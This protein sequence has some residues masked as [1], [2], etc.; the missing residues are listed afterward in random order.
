MRL[1]LLSIAA[2]SITMTACA[3]TGGVPEPFPTPGPRPTRTCHPQTGR[4]LRHQSSRRRLLHCRNGSR[5]TRCTV[6]ERWFGPSRVRLQRTHRV[7]LQPAWD[8]GAEDRRGAAQRRQGRPDA[9]RSARRPCVLRHHR[10]GT[11][12]RR[13]VDRWRRVRA[14]T[15]RR[16]SRAGRTARRGLLGSTLHRCEA[17]H[18][19][20]TSDRTTND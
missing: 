6:P 1:I 9:G 12:A 20:T 13:H 17:P 8:R 10:K 18:S 2:A 5:A 4:N 16:R 14:R 19:L 7:R 15:E 11:F 3:S